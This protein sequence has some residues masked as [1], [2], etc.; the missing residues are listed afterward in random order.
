MKKLAFVLVVSCFYLSI[1]LYG[2]DAWKEQPVL[3]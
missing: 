3:T 2:A 1:N